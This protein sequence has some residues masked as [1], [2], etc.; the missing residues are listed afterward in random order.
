MEIQ[1]LINLRHSVRSFQN[2]P[3]PRE[4]LQVILKAGT[5]APSAKNRQP[6][7]YTLLTNPNR[8]TEVANCFESKIDEI[9]RQ[10][11]EKAESL[12]DLEM[13]T[14]T[15]SIIRQA[16][17]V[18]F[19][20]YEHENS[21]SGANLSLSELEASFDL[22]DILSIGAAIE[23]MILQ[24]TSMGIASLWV[25][26]TLLAHDELCQLLELKYPFV[27]TVLFGY[28]YSRRS[29]RISFEDKTDWLE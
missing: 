24:A 14:S 16:P 2:T 3:L 13:A 28:E 4:A 21:E 22:P 27:S 7:R 18:L 29:T 17:A 11:R 8:I 6:W 12:A 25:C 15:A 20:Q 26:D 19:I 9:K 23:N 10:R 5:L 1:N